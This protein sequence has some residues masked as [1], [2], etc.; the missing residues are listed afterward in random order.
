M[1]AMNCV[2]LA[3]LTFFVCFVVSCAHPPV[4]EADTLPRFHEGAAADVVVRF[5]RWNTIFILR[6]DTRQGGFLPI[7]NREDVAHWVDRPDI[8]HDLAVVLVGFSYSPEQEEELFSAWKSLL[9]E[10]G[11]RRIV[12]LRAGLNNKIDGLPILHDSAIADAL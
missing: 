7:F 3:V 12:M 6:P 10:H 9:G 8:R 1:K 2:R 4:L 5:S 11:F